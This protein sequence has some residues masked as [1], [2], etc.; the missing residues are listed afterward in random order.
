MNIRK[1]RTEDLQA[2]SL[3]VM[4]TFKSCCGDDYFDES[5][6]QNVLDAFDLKKNTE[7]ELLQKLEKTKIMYVAE[8][9]EGVIGFVRGR[10][11]EVVSLAVDVSCHRKGVGN[12]LM[13][14]FEEDARSEGAVFIK[15]HSSVFAVSFYESMGY[16]KLSGIQNFKGLKVYDMKKVL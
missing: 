9:E 10:S 15:L 11:D 14:R 4:R 6:V 3:L 2:V 16:E 12:I 8:D 1:F 7:E 13:K 5:G